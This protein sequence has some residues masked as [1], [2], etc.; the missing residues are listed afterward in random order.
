VNA[1]TI[2]VALYPPPV[3]EQWGDDLAGEVAAGG[4]RSW[5]DTIGGAVRLWVRPGEWPEHAPGQTHRIILVELAA[6]ATIVTL[7]LRAAGRPT[8][9]FTASFAH[10]ATS[11]WA[12]VIIAGLL[13]AAPLPPAHWVALRP[14]PVAC[15]RTLAPP[16][17][18]FTAMYLLAQSSLSDHHA[19]VGRYLA[20]CCYWAVLAFAGLQLCRLASLVFAVLV[21]PHARRLRLATL[22]VG[23]GLA[24][25][26]AQNLA[27]ETASAA[28][29]ALSVGLGGLAIAVLATGTG[30]RRVAPPSTGS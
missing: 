9:L 2:L 12:A 27:S 25:A 6:A 7:L 28:A 24:M 19:I 3:R 21:P 29:G 16:A 1:A 26:A 4:W 13:L 20:P 11:A 18:A 15:L 23:T 17:A 30:L 5:P 8:A 10:L 22:T 14:L